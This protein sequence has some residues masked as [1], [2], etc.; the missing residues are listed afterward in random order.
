MRWPAWRENG[1]GARHIVGLLVVCL[2]LVAVLALQALSAAQSHR[3]VAEGVLRDYGALAADEFIR[4]SANELGYYGHLPALT[5]LRQAVRTD[6]PLPDSDALGRNADERTTTALSLIDTVVDFDPDMNAVRTA[7]R[8]PGASVDRWI[9]DTLV[10][11]ASG[12]DWEE[13]GGYTTYH[14]VVDGGLQTLVYGPLAAEPRRLVG[15]TVDTGALSE[16][17]GR[18]VSR[19][20]LLPPSLAENV[21]TNDAIRLHV[22]SPA[23]EPLFISD[24]APAGRAE[25]YLEISRPFGDIYDGILDGVTVRASID[26][27]AAMQLVIGGLPRS[28]LPVLIG[29]LALTLGMLGVAIVLLRRERAVARL[30]SDFVSRVSHELRTPL[31][32]IRLFAETL[33]LER[34]RSSDEHR[35]ALEI[36]DKESR[37][38][39]AL[40][41]NVLQFARGERREIE[42]ALARHD[43]GALLGG[44]L[45]ELQRIADERHARLES[46]L[47]VAPADVDADA[48]H[49]IVLNLVDN[50]VKYGPPGQTIT[51][52]TAVDETNGHRVTRL[53]VDDEGPGISAADRDR[54]WRPFV[55]LERDRRSETAGTGIGLAVVH[56]LVHQHGGH[57]WVETNARGGARVVVELPVPGYPPAVAAAGSAARTGSTGAT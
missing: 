49:Q 51:L 50:A 37:R 43:V 42:L 40:V 2:G 52:G 31:T 55:R 19:G 34:D 30:R 48:L 26:P 36:I 5:A 53:W 22:S 33:L 6:A 46:Q 20:P 7:G 25:R 39:A 14:G 10:T 9:R 4:R 28:R 23:G 1:S 12:L 32:Q 18:S 11:V 29:L 24:D 41:E 45:E 15:F 44:R 13:T 57:A 16:W 54:V 17:F 56:E 3:A 38:L 47:V 21:L 27:E 35:R 8:A